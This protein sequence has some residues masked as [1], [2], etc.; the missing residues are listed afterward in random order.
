VPR[1]T[2]SV[3]TSQFSTRF[4]CPGPS[5]RSHLDMEHALGQVPWTGDVDGPQ[6]VATI[7]SAQLH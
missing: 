6:R 4:S 5:R 1:D 3:T 7:G 2:D